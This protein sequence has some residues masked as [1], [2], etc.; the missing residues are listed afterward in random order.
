MFEAETKIYRSLLWLYSR[1]KCCVHNF[2]QWTVFYEFSFVREKFIPFTV[3][4]KE[5]EIRYWVK[6]IKNLRLCVYYKRAESKF[7]K[8]Q[9]QR[10]PGPRG[11]LCTL[12]TT[13]QDKLSLKHK[14]FEQQAD[15]LIPIIHIKC[16]G[17]NVISNVS[18]SGARLST[19]I[20][21]AVWEIY[22]M[23]FDLLCSAS[24]KS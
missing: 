9:W 6:K 24:G 4:I 2:S 11:I 15:S 19:K 8:Y 10:Q 14:T 5:L 13:L 21:L 20:Y 18:N 1:K 7:K 3:W 12:L 17:K 23:K 22:R 16:S